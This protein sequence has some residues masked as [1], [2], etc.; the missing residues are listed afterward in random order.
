MIIWGYLQFFSPFTAL[1][2]GPVTAVVLL[3]HFFSRTGEGDKRPVRSVL[4]RRAFM[5]PF[6][7]VAAWTYHRGV[8]L[9]RAEYGT[10]IG[11][12]FAGLFPALALFFLMFVYAPRWYAGGDH[13]PRLWVIRG[14]TYLVGVLLGARWLVWWGS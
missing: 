13:T 3:F 1:V 8:V 12:V 14:A 2:I 11:H 9:L 7:L 4:T 10:D 6:I 5:L